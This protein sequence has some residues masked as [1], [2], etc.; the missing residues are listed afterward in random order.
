MTWTDFVVNADFTPYF[1]EVPDLTGVRLRSVHLDGWDPTVTLRLDLPRFPDRWDGAPGDTMQ[2]QIQ[3]IM[4][5]DFLMEGWQ[6]P[7]T[8]DVVLRALPEHRLAVQ[9]VAPGVA[10]SFTANASVL[11]GKISVF[12]QAADGGDSGPRSFSRPLETR[13]YPALPPAYANTFYERV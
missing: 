2:C 10:V 8:A 5:Q 7:V 3:F 6:P 13:L 9:L 11:A 12:T 4:V 1:D